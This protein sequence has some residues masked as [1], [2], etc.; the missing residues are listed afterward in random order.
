MEQRLYIYSL[1]Q[2]LF[3]NARSFIL[4]ARLRSVGGRYGPAPGLLESAGVA[5]ML[6]SVGIYSPPTVTELDGVIYEIHKEMTDKGKGA[7][8]FRL[9]AEID[10]SP[11][12]FTAM[13]MEAK[14][15][16]EL[17]HTVRCLDYIAAYPDGATWLSYEWH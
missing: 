14:I 6:Q 17:D 12:L 1:F 13:M 8:Y 4:D 11:E 16:G 7:G 3:I 15:L 5:G 10:T 9:R 2:S